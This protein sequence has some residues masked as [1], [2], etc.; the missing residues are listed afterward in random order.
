MLIFNA[1]YGFLLNA[2]STG[3]QT[4]QKHSRREDKFWSLWYHREAIIGKFD[5]IFFIF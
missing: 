3:R 1:L 2:R 4:W 5:I